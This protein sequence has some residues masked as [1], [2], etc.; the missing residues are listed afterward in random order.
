MIRTF[1]IAVAALLYVIVV[2]HA[3]VATVHDAPVSLGAK[4]N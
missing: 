2:G 4:W 1:A 3:H